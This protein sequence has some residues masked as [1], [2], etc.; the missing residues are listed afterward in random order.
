MKAEAAHFFLTVINFYQTTW[1]HIAEDSTLQYK[2]EYFVFHSP[3]CRSFLQQEKTIT[4]VNIDR[5]K[6]ISVK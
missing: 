4:I 3:D 6:P 1:H 2:Y 5:D